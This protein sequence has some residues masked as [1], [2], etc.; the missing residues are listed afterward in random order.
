[1]LWTGRVYVLLAGFVLGV[2]GEWRAVGG[3]EGPV[4]SFVLVDFKRALQIP[5]THG[6]FWAQWEAEPLE[7]DTSNH[8][9]LFRDSKG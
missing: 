1:M 3:S 5:G 6:W 4:L 2:W 8:G 7:F 9:L